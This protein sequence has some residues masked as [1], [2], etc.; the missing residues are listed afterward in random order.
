MALVRYGAEWESKISPAPRAVALGV[1]DGL[2]IGHRAVI[3]AACGVADNGGGFLRAT[4]FS[5]AGVPKAATGKLITTQQEDALLETLGTDEWIEAPFSSLQQLSPQEFV[6]TVLHRRL[7][8]RHIC[9]GYNY[10][11][12]N[13]GAGDVETLKALCEPLGITVTVVPPQ[14]L[15]GQHISSTRV[16][17]ALNEGDAEQA[18]RLLG[19]PFTVAFPITEG[20]HR[21]RQWGIPT[22]NQVFP[23][24][25][26]VPRLGVYASLVVIDG[27]QH[28]A[29]TNVGVHPT[30]GGSPAPQAETWISG[31]SGDLYGK[32]VAVQLI[33][34]L[35]EEQRFGD[36]NALR[37]Q[38]EQDEHKALTILRGEPSARAVLFDFDDT[39]QDRFAAC[40]QTA[41][42]LM[43]KYMPY[44]SPAERA[45]R[46]R[47]MTEENNGGYVD[48]PA[49]FESLLQ[50]W[51]WVGLDSAEELAWWFRREFPKHVTLFPETVDVLRQ[52]K[53]RGYRLGIVTNGVAMMQH[54]KLDLCGIKP[55]VDTVLVAGEEEVDKPYREIF[56]RAAARLC[57]A[58]TN[59]VFVGDH[60]QND[61]AGA[62]SAG[63]NAIYL[64]SC[65]RGNPPEQVREI[66]RLQELLPCLG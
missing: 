66:S 38:I 21:G 34:F 29:V 18:A 49:F 57:V 55:L 31:F 65:G 22:I 37:A 63:M 46:A 40:L 64:N 33:R 35:R 3:A 7:G 48:Y 27:T 6:A 25:Y 30:V 39:L 13:G 41:E 54:R 56:L 2:H 5:I 61:I 52:L 36:V 15:D 8:A 32:T 60:P 50:R 58:P 45:A 43:Q 53:Q 17:A 12:G 23:Q 42:V 1:F 19:R 47:Q 16:R 62:V 4:V 44:A 10:R 9:C 51:Q 28:M 20:H 59:C 24:G 26:V 14:M 11:F